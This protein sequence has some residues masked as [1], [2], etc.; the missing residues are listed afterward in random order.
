MPSKSPQQQRLFGMVTKYLHEKEAGS[1]KEYLDEMTDKYGKSLADKIKSIADGRRKKTGDKR[2]YTKGVDLETAR[3][4]ARTK[5]ADMVQ[6]ESIVLLK[7]D[8]YVKQLNEN[9]E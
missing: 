3:D 5:H 7:F 8:D 4:F 1:G 2:E 6:A 9:K